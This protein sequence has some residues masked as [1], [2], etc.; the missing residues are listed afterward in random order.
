[1]NIQYL[2]IERPYNFSSPFKGEEYAALIYI[3]DE[4]ISN[5]EQE[6]LSNQIVTSGCR[7][8]VCTGYNSSNWDNS[9]DMADIKRNGG[10]VLDENLVLTTWHDN[11]SLEDI[12]FFF[13]N[14]T[15]F[16]NFIANRLIV[17]L[18]GGNESVLNNIRNETKKQLTTD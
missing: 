8:A 13:L 18:V 11:E 16:G 12:V 9:I 10:E 15:S 2:Q 14:N 7:Y 6:S 4:N 17:L 3:A 5:E 1:M